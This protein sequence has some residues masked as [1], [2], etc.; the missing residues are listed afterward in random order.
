[1]GWVWHPIATEEEPSNDLSSAIAHTHAGSMF[2]LLEKSTVIARH[3]HAQ[4]R[5]GRNY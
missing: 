3:T 5:K 4:Y 2:A 1:L